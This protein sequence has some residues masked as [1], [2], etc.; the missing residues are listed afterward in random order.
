MN[1][2][3]LIVQAAAIIDQPHTIMKTNRI[4]TLFALLMAA[5]PSLAQERGFFRVYP[6]EG[7]SSIPLPLM[8]TATEAQDGG[9]IVAINNFQGGFGGPWSRLFRLSAEG[10]LVNSVPFGDENSFHG[11]INIFRHPQNPGIC[12][13]A[14]MNFALYQTTPYNM[15]HSSPYFIHFDDDLNI[16]LQHLAEWPEAYQNA[17]NASGARCILTHDGDVFGTFCF[18]LPSDTVFHYRHRLYAIMSPEGDFEQANEDTTF[19]NGLGAIGS[20]D[21]VFVFPDS[22]QNGVLHGTPNNV[23]GLYR[24]NK[25]LEETLVNDYHLIYCDT[26]ISYPYQ[27]DTYSL[28]WLETVA[29]PVLPLDDST[30]LFSIRGDE[31]LSRFTLDTN[32]F[33]HDLAPVLFQTDMEGNIRQL[34]IL[35]RM[36]D[37]LEGTPYTSAALTEPDGTGQRYIYHCSYN[38]DESYWEYPNALTITKLTDALTILWR[39]V[40][41]LPDAYLEPYHLLVTSDGG[42]LVVGLMGPGE[43]PFNT[44][45]YWFALKLEADGTV[46]TDEIAVT[47]GIYFYPNPAKETIH[48]SMPSDKKPQAIGLYDQQGRL[49]RTQRNNLESIN[50]EGLA[51]G[52][53]TM[54]VT[55]EDGKVLSDKVVKE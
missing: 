47:D 42:C 9:S 49:L 21:G 34:N 51:A 26:T 14:G 52:V 17:I 31:F 22:G 48:L 2:A 10:E 5:I 33:F 35:G 4:I 39:K 36:N 12:I 46:G 41:S 37:T 20:G 40:Y 32:L 54:R 19:Y 18:E 7:C 13:G 45:Y 43:L 25:N 29:N 11:V 3:N 27:R 44:T 53:Y 28:V 8:M 23:H 30:L 55:L 16:S 38:R 24:L 6:F 1:T 15:Y 50:L